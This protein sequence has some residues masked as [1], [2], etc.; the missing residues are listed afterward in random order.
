M[1]NLNKIVFLKDKK[2]KKENL[3]TPA[4]H[5]NAIPGGSP[6]VGNGNPLQS[7][8]LEN[9]PSEIGWC[10]WVKGGF[11]CQAHLHGVSSHS[12]PAPTPPWCALLC[13]CWP[14]PAH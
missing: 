14:K 11:R 5:E 8:C 3:P 10:P 7:S 2:K 4:G 12:A 13:Y 1:L 6:R 9:C